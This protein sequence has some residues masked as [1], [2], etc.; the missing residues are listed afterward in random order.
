MN[1][2]ASISILIAVISTSCTNL[3]DVEQNSPQ[4][5]SSEFIFIKPETSYSRSIL[6]DTILAYDLGKYAEYGYPTDYIAGITSSHLNPLNKKF[7]Y[8]YASISSPCSIT[9]GLPETIPFN[10]SINEVTLSANNTTK[11]L[12]KQANLKD[13]FGSMV[14]YNLS[15]PQY[16]KSE[17][18]D[19][20]SV[21][22][23][24]PEIIEI[25][26][27]EISSKEQLYP[28]CLYNRF[29]LKWNADNENE[30]GV[31]IVVEWHGSMIFGEDYPNA[32]IRST[33]MIPDTGE[34][35]LNPD[36]FSGIPDTALCT[37]TVLRGNIENELV[38]GVSCKLVAESHQCIQ[39]ILIRNAVKK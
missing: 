36:I 18:S 29:K 1:R 33:D 35:Y 11:S 31:M 25:S 7:V 14:T 6:K 32:Y 21:D 8:G 2:L 28:L 19:G 37:L 26:Y 5:D 3:K 22:M 24:V 20:V 17:E 12:P 34:T 27:P 9:K 10:I 15:D 16:T 38:N 30:N 4:E 23:Y 13:M 39:F